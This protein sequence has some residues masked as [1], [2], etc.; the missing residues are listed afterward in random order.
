MPNNSTQ[1]LEGI[2]EHY[3]GKRYR[4]IGVGKNT[5]TEEAVVIYQPLYESDV[6]YWVRPYEMFVETIEKDGKIIERFR[7]INE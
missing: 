6:F 3:K 4:V 5:E 2:Y 7:K 1:T